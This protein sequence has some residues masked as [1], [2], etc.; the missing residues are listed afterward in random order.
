MTRLVVVDDHPVFRRGLVA[1]LEASGHEVVGQATNGREAVDVV[2]DT[3]PEV[4]LMDL[5]MPDGNGFEATARITAEHPE[6]AV[7]VVTLFGDEASVARALRAGA[8]GYVGKHA[9]PGQIVAAV[10][11]ATTGALWIDGGVERPRFGAADGSADVTAAAL[12][13]GLTPRELVIADLVGRGLTNPVIAARLGLAPKT[14]ANYVSSVLLKLGADDRAE[15]ARIV[16]E[17]RDRR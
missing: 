11:A 1:L 6:V 3:A 15:A 12:P 8:T 7:V 13:G 10:E 9:E 17:R 16:R 5:A 4:V 2:R 14:V